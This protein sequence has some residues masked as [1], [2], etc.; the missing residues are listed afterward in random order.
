MEY[1]VEMR[2]VIREIYSVEADSP[3]EARAMAEDWDIKDPGIEIDQE[4]WEVLDVRE[5]P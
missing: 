4:D 2:R 3:E 1:Q 5:S